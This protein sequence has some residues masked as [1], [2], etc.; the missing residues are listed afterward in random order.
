MISNEIRENIKFQKEE[1]GNLNSDAKSKVDQIIKENKESIE[2]NK[3][4]FEYA[5]N[6]LKESINKT[7]VDELNKNNEQI[8]YTADVLGEKLEEVNKTLK[9]LN[10]TIEKVED[11]DKQKINKKIEKIEKV[12]SRIDEKVHEKK[13]RFLVNTL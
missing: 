1:L 8:S 12:L 2:D 6:N 7:I 5:F 13:K 10:V 9:L 4:I 3:K 11:S